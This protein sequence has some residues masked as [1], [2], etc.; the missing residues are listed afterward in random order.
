MAFL[1]FLLIL[2]IALAVPALITIV[3]PAAAQ[4]E[5]SDAVLPPAARIRLHAHFEEQ[6][7]AL[8]ARTEPALG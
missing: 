3:Q 5:R 4:S 2:C 6:P 7:L 8:I 1:R